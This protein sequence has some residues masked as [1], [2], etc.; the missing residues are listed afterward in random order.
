MKPIS[1]SHFSAGILV[2]MVLM[3]LGFGL[4]LKLELNAVAAASRAH[5]A[6]MARQEL[7]WAVANM[8]RRLGNVVHDLAEWDETRQHLADP[9]FYAIWRD[10]RVPDSGLAPKSIK[11]L[12]L[13]DA[14]GTILQPD[15]QMP[16][17]AP[18]IRSATSL[19]RKE[20]GRDFIYL[21]F[22]IR[23]Q[24][25][26]TGLIGY[27]GLKLDLI[28]E[29]QGTEHGRFLAV[30][31]LSVNLTD[32]A[33]VAPGELLA[34][35]Q[36]LPRPNLEMQR[37][38]QGFE[39]ALVH[40]GLV[41]LAVLVLAIGIIHRLLIRPLRTLSAEIAGLQ[42]RPLE[43]PR[44]AGGRLLPLQELENLRTSFYDYQKRL[45]E[46]HRNLERNSRDFYDQARQDTLAGTYN[47]RAF[48][49]DW[50]SVEQDKRVGQCSLILFDCDHF[51]AIN[52]TYGHP[53]GDTVIRALA[54]CLAHALRSDDRLYRLG[55]DEF[56]TLM[57]GSNI[58]TALVVAERCLEQVQRY[59]FGQYG[60]TEPV[61]ISIGLAHGTAPLDLATL[62][63]QADLAMYTAKRPGHPK[64]VVYEDALG[65]LSSLVDNRDVSA[66][67][68]AIR[69]PD[70]LEFRYQPIFSLPVMQPEYA[71]AL[72]RIRYD[73]QIIGPAA[74][75]A[76][77]HNR[78]LD[79]EFDLAVISAV[80]RDL[81]AGLGALQLG[82]SINLS[83]PGVVNDK[84]IK[85]L[86]E[87]KQAYPTRKIVVEITETALITQMAVATANIE[88]LRRAGCLV[89]LDDF[90]SGYSSLRYLATMPVDMVK[91][92]MSLVRLLDQED[93][94]HRLVVEDIAE[95]VATAGYDLVAE[96]IES[97]ALLAKV[98][99]V[100]FSHG[101]GFHLDRIQG[102]G[103]RDQP[104]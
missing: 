72:C 6:A 56:A 76:I 36:A 91:F 94:R 58:D 14:A 96:G 61:T 3:L 81:A 97:E 62:H 55:G 4:S 41:I 38:L 19:Y 42:E 68:E 69:Q 67:Y 85:A 8:E 50:V 59:D 57:P 63:K 35:L 46:M 17:Q 83:A 7:A 45:A 54:G 64:I 99:E 48:D 78:R 74:I 93:L 82:V 100:G 84:V 25:S 47:R 37:L 43:P 22:P 28:D 104:G 34:H 53:V 1:L 11:A 12:A 16:A 40:L 20:A 44:T 51:K 65:G 29:L 39:T 88:R 90:G 92:D 26:G 98:I 49:E 27:G 86:L 15:A 66:V 13:Y 102:S 71:E 9:Q 21:F 33:V 52:D 73:G 77:V 5:T 103:M 80:R 24:P 18:E 89:A 79:V 31:R 75:F 10:K 2:L 101:Q 87:L 23:S 95:M 32:G 30:E 70:L 60:I